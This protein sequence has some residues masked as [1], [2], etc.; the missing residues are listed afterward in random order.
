MD[1][2]GKVQT[3]HLRRRSVTESTQRDAELR[4]PPDLAGVGLDLPTAVPARAG[5]AL[6]ADLGIV[7]HAGRVGAEDESV[8]AV[9]VGVEDHSERIHLVQAGVTARVGGDDL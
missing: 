4:G 7:L 2:A 9:A 1:V 6:V 8:L 3:P 5:A